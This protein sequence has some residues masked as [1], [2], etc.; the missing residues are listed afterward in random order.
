VDVPSGQAN[1]LDENDALWISLR[2]RLPTLNGNS[3]WVPQGW[4]LEDHTIDYFDAAREWI[5]ITGLNQ[6][7]CLYDRTN[8][9]W[10]TFWAAR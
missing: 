10:S 9:S 5:A 8:R 3:G 1:F 6:T 4:R 7:V 2:T